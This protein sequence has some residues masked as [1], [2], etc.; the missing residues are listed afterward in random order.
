[1]IRLERITDGAAEVALLLL[2]RREKRNAL[3]PDM[4]ENIRACAERLHADPR[5]PNALVL[6]GEGESF[7]SGFDLSLCRDDELAM[8]A[9]LTRLSEAARALR[10]LPIPVVAAAHGAAI[11]GGCALI[12]GADFIITNSD[13]RL[14]YPVVRLGVS[15]AVSA[16]LLALHTGAAHARERLLDPELIDGREALRIGLAHECVD[17]P[18]QVRP[19]AMALAAALGAKPHHAIAATKHWLNELDGSADDALLQQALDTSLSL[20]GGAEERSR[21]AALWKG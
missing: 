21:L 1:M 4:L 16:P 8:A 10:R 19:R 15:P 13:A 6:A 11:A 9:L 17:Q 20:A 18:E 14:G 3:T 2:D 12:A 7:C 5:R